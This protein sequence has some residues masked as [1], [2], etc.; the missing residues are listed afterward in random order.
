MIARYPDCPNPDR[1]A[2]ARVG[3]Q[4]RARLAADPGVERLPVEAAEIWGV[5][6][7]A[8]PD[9]CAR[10]IA[11]IDATARPSEVLDHGYTEAWRTSYSGDVERADPFVHM[12]ERR[13]DDLLGV[14]H[15]WGETL[16]G[17]R[18]EAGQQFREHMDWFWTKAP[19]WKVEA[20]RGGQRALTAMIYLN[21]VEQGGETAFPNLGLSVPPQ[22]GTLLVWN[23]AGPDGALNQF[24][25]HAGTPVLRGVKYIVTKWYR[26]R[27]WG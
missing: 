6:D 23:N 25:L 17:Q 14:P 5:A 18:Y 16:Q 8:S 9:E 22:P 2:L 19:Y 15:K 7:F 24:T 13:I 10:L 12:I 20:N 21:A 3:A 1:A 4:V 26:T 11:L 27:N